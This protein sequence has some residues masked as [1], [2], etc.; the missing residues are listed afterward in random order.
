MPLWYGTEPLYR[1][2]ACTVPRCCGMVLVFVSDWCF[3]P[4]RS[5]A[6]TTPRRRQ[7][8]E[9]MCQGGGLPAEP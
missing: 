8:A 6:E 9:V 7:G 5:N 1:V 3:V 2:K 4:Y